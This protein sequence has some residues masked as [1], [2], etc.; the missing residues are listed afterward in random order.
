MPKSVRV[1][2]GTDSTLPACLCWG[3]AKLLETSKAGCLKESETTSH[4]L[5]RDFD[6]INLGDICQNSPKTKEIGGPRAGHAYAC[7]DGQHTCLIISEAV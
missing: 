6:F 4:H 1:F 2:K 5:N 3:L 7:L